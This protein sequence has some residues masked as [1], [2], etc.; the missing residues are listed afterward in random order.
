VFEALNIAP[1]AGDGGR[2]GDAGDTAERL[3]V[4]E[5][6]REEALS[7]VHPA[8]WKAVVA[9]HA[10][11]LWAASVVIAGALAAVVAVALT[12]A[13]PVSASSGAPQVDVLELTATDRIPEGWFG[14]DDGTVAAD[15]LG[16]TIFS[17]PGWNETRDDDTECVAAVITAQ[18]PPTDDFDQ[19][20]W[21]YGGDFSSGCSVGAFP[22]TVEV[23]VDRGAPDELTG[24]Y[25]AARALQFVLDGD[26]VG[27]FV[28]GGSD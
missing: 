22:A 26:R 13:S 28:D 4:S 19:Y 21:S 11:P 6:P 25:P 7:E 2:D 27:V 8:R 17:Y 20:D 10:K 15:Y 18:I 1:P 5:T 3:P 12:S 14:A 23:P 16:F 24:R 9:R